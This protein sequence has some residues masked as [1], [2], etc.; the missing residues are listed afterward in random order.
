MTFIG[1]DHLLRRPPRLASGTR[2]PGA[3]WRPT[4]RVGCRQKMEKSIESSCLVVVYIASPCRCTGW[5]IVRQLM[6]ALLFERADHRL[7]KDIC[8]VCNCF[9]T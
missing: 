8:T 7:Q 9:R 3:L 5:K 4:W 6:P 2:T 1:D